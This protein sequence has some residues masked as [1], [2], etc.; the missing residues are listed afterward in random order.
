MVEGKIRNGDGPAGDG[1]IHH[2]AAG[3]GPHAGDGAASV[4]LDDTGLADT[5]K[6]QFIPKGDETLK[7]DGNL[8]YYKSDAMSF[9]PFIL[10]G[11][12]LLCFLDGMMFVVLAN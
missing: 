5:S 12:V 7:S 8:L 6:V 4:L 10:G 11:V 9:G 2:G 3:P 1:E